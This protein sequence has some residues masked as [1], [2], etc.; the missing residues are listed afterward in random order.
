MEFVVP[1]LIGTSAP[2]VGCSR[3]QWVGSVVLWGWHGAWGNLK[4][5]NQLEVG[6]PRLENFPV[7]PTLIEEK[8]GCGGQMGWENVSMATRK[9]HP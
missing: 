5:K 1:Y 3:P 6:S 8:P 7:L 9:S 4:E 2:A